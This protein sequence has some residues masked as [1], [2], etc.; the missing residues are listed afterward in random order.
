[1]KTEGVTRMLSERPRGAGVTFPAVLLL[2]VQAAS[3]AAQCVADTDPHKCLRIGR[4]TVVFEATVDEITFRPLAEKDPSSGVFGPTGERLIHFRDMRALKGTSQEVLVAAVFGSED[5]YYEF[6]RGQRYLVV[7]NRLSDGRFAPSDLSRPIGTSK[8]FSTYIQS[9]GL[10]PNGGQLWGDVSMPTQWKEWAMTFGPVQG[11]R[12][13]VQGPVALTT[14]TD[15][16]GEYHFDKLP[17]GAYTVRVDVQQAAPYLQSLESQNVDVQPGNSCAELEFRAESRGQ[18]EGLL[19][20]ERGD[21]VPGVFLMLHPADFL[22]PESCCPGVGL[23]TDI[24][25]RY[26]F[27]DLPPGRYFVGV[28]AEIGPN[29]R[30][31]YV[32]AYAATATGETTI[33]VGIGEGVVVEPIRLTRAIAATVSGKVV[34]SGGNPVPDVDVAIWWTSVRG[35]EH[36]EYRQTDREGQFQLRAWQGVRYT[37]EVGSHDAPAARLV[38]PRLNEPITIT[39]T[40]R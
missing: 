19:I 22:G 40:E 26:V 16:H 39:L 24:H 32:E 3:V 9:L 38:S 18:I 33:P 5:C 4:D 27:S 36:R 35:H 2:L 34:N 11:A 17:W 31:P 13:T 7:A 23:S 6:E 15:A 1:M 14:T 8:G 20:D 12:V 21:S 30:Q 29:P 28:N 37:L 10:L 25:G